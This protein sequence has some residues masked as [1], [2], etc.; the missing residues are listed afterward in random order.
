MVR[1]LFPILLIVFIDGMGA[2]I[3][4]PVLPFYAVA[5]G[6][7]PFTVGLL[8]SCYALAQIAF[9]PYLGRLSDRIGRKPVLVVAQI[10]TFASLLLL[11]FANS[12]LLIFV[13][14][15][16]DGITGA[17]LSTAQS[18]VS[19]ATPPESRAAGLGLIGAASGLGFIAGPLLSGLALSL[20][21]SDFSA[22]A[23]LAAGFS[24]TSVVLTTIVFRETLPPHMRNSSSPVRPKRG[25]AAL[26]GRARS[27]ELGPFYLFAMGAQLVF[28]M[29]TATFTLYTLNRLG[30]DSLSNAIFLGLFGLMLVAM[31]GALVGRLVN[32][33]GEYRVLAA[34]FV[35]TA[36]GFGLAALAPQQAVPW[37]DR[38]ELADELSQAGEVSNQLAL[39]PPEAGAG[40]GA[41][42]FVLFGLLPGPLGYT[43]QMPTINALLTKKA[44]ASEIGETL[45]ISAAFTGAG[46]VIGPVLG[47]YLFAELS[48]GAPHALGAILSV[49]M[50]AILLTEVRDPA[51]PVGRTSPVATR[52]GTPSSRED[53]Q[54]ET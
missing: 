3:L 20:S 28:T 42:I 49:V 15:I 43:L 18:A 44:S 13:S 19:D 6:A 21:G 52:S 10:G 33:F 36:I 30:F 4:I 29:F 32:R 35:M 50:V 24:L 11:G 1:R 17:N 47:G 2:T 26:V 7:D 38:D 48:P 5:F 45:G 46:T 31:Q 53:G 25:G 41:F 39:L 12:L 51:S 16:L 14:R 27:P 22:P 37:Y 9:G 23:F 40:L 54:T 8:L 34:S